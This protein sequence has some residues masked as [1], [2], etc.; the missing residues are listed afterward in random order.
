MN[1]EIDATIGPVLQTY[2]SKFGVILSALATE[3]KPGV[4][5]TFIAGSRV[6]GF[7]LE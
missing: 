1:A 2:A 5:M 6:L 3:M 7:T 4:Q